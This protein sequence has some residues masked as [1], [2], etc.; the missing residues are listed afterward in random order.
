M[1]AYRQLLLVEASKTTM[2]LW[3][4]YQFMIAQ[5]PEFFWR[6]VGENIRDQVRCA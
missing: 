5:D 2:L 3:F 4:S 6:I 1:R